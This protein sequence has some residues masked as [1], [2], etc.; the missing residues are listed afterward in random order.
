MPNTTLPSTAQ[1][2]STQILAQMEQIEGRQL[3][4]GI[5]N[6]RITAPLLAEALR[7]TG[8]GVDDA[9]LENALAKLSREGQII[10]V[11]PGIYRSRV[12]ETTRLIRLV[13]QRLP[14]RSFQESKELIE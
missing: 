7:A 9:A 11:E 10:E 2:T 1:V 6:T 14:G 8:V 3:N 5:A 12:A 13:R 4:F